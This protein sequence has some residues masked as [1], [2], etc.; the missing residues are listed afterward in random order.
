MTPDLILRNAN[1]HTM[2]PA[3]PQARAMALAGGRI[4]ALG[5]D[6]GDLVRPG[7]RVIDAGGRLVLPG[8]QDAH[9]HLLSGGVELGVVVVVLGDNQRWVG[10]R[11]IQGDEQRIG[12]RQH[13]EIVHPVCDVRR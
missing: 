8:F 3:R 7:M 10:A 2:D 4:V 1:I 13:L 6:L 12:R 9:V 11:A 5:D